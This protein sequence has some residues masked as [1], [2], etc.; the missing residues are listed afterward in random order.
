MGEAKASVVREV[1]MPAVKVAAGIAL[2]FGVLA[3]CQAL[4]DDGPGEG[5]GPGVKR[6]CKEFVDKRLKSPGSADY[7][8]TATNVG[9]RWTVVGTVDSE[10]SFGASLR[11]RVEC[12]MESGG[13]DYTATSV[14]VE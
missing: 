9:T 14:T 12:V 4:G 2:L 10:N 1:V 11:S 13:A 6:A 8:L 5:S 7:N 3:G